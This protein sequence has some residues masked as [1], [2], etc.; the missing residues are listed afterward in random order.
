MYSILYAHVFLT[1]TLLVDG[2]LTENVEDS[3][4]SFRVEL[5]VCGHQVDTH[6]SASAFYL[7]QHLI[8]LSPIVMQIVAV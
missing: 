7:S 2:R 3:N 4:D 6:W 8:Y 1:W 5:R